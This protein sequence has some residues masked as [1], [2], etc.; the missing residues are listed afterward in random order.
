[1]NLFIAADGPRKNAPE[2][3]KIIL[4]A[5]GRG[6][7][8]NIE[9]GDTNS[10][11]YSEKAAC[12]IIRDDWSGSIFRLITVIV[13]EAAH[14]TTERQYA[15]SLTV[16][17]NEKRSVQT[18]IDFWEKVKVSANLIEADISA[19]NA[20]IESNKELLQQMDKGYSWWDIPI[21]GTEKFNKKI[22][23]ALKLIKKVSPEYHEIVLKAF[24]GGMIADGGNTYT[25][26]HVHPDTGYCVII[27]DD[28]NGSV[29][30]LVS[31]L[32]HEAAHVHSILKYSSNK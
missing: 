3:Y 11:V 20:I 5:F 17:E 18:E 14:V 26:S 7:I 1:M 16:L 29:A 23:D 30:R 22:N 2:D 9:A 4:S 8:V 13:H 25:N 19:V 6:K 21:I 15:E 31:T 32:I 12:N 24:Q 10:H 27:K 28:W